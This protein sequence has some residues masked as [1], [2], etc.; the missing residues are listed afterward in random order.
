[1]RVGIVSAGAMGSAV[2]RT[3]LDGGAEVVTTLEGRSE[4]TARLA[5]AAGLACVP[6]LGDVVDDVDVVLSIGPPGEAEKIAAAIAEACNAAGA[7]PLV[8]DLN[9]ISPATARKVESSLA[10][11]GLDL[12]DGSI[13][14]PP[15]TK[16]GTTRIYLSGTRA[17]EVAALPFR[18]VDLIEVG[19]DVGTASAVKMST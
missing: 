15:P 18:G 5:E 7:A 14:G 10:G 11:A 19:D 12:V 1:M 3:L 16:A 9:A 6:T 13:S 17:D 4:R 2:G 8:A